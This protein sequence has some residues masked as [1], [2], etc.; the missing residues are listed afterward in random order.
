MVTG[1]PAGTGVVVIGKFAEVVV[2]AATWTLA[3]TEATAVLELESAI[4]APPGGAGPFRIATLEELPGGLPP[5]TEDGERLTEARLADA[6]VT[7]RVAVACD[8]P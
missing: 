3:G 4:T 7:V 5:T 6:G 1:V 8:L 2:P